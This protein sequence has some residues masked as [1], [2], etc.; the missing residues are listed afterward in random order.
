MG[1]NDVNSPNR[2]KDDNGTSCKNFVPR[3]EACVEAIRPRVIV[4]WDGSS[5]EKESIRENCCCRGVNFVKAIILRSELIK[6]VSHHT[7]NYFTE[8]IMEHGEW[9]LLIKCCTI[10]IFYTVKQNKT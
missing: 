10:H 6:T 2:E 5:K 4:K 1:V 9:D 8:I 7:N 3:W